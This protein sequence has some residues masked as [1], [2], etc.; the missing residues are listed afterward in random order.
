M[1][2]RRIGQMIR[3]QDRNSDAAALYHL[4]QTTGTIQQIRPRR[5][6]SGQRRT[7]RKKRAFRSEQSKINRSHRTR[8]LPEEYG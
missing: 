7:R 3:L 6:I 4:E 2:F 8:G 5:R 1:G